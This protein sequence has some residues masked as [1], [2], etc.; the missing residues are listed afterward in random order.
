MISEATVGGKILTADE[1][2]SFAEGR[3]SHLYERLGAHLVQHDGASGVQF[4]VWAPKA[5][6][7]SVVGDFDQWN[8]ETDPLQRA[9]D[10]SGLWTGF[11]RNVRESAIYK[12]YV[13]S[14][15]EGE[16]R[17]KMD[18]FGFFHERSPKTASLVWDLQYAWNDG[19][20]MARQQQRNALDQPISIYEVHF[21][22]WRRVPEEN[23]RFLTYREAA[24]L[25]VQQ[26][27]E[28]GFTHVEF[29]PL[30]EHP[31]YA[32]W[33]YQVTGFFAPTSRY[34]TPQDLM[35]LIDHLHQHGIGVIL[36]WVP[37]H[38][39]NDSHGLGLFD[40]TPTFEPG[41]PQQATHPEWNSYLFDYSRPEVRSFLLSSAFF[42]LEKY[43]AD[44]LR[45]DA[46]A[47]MLYRDHGHA[48]GH[49]SAN[50]S[51]GREN[52]AAADFIRELNT[53]LYAAFPGIQTYAE[54]STAWPKVSRP[55]YAGGLGFGL[56]W[57][58]GFAH[59]ILRYFGRE[60]LFRKLAHNELTFRGLYAFHENFVLPLSHDD[61]IP[62]KGS[63]LARMP[64]NQ[65]ERFSNLRLLL[66]YM[67]LQ[68]GK[69]LLFMGNEFGQWRDWNHDLSLDW[70]LLEQSSH[71]GVAQ[72][73]TDL[74]MTYRRERALHATDV[75]SSSFEWSDCHDAE[76]STISWFRRHADEELLV[77]C[78][79]SQ[80]FYANFRLGVSQGGTWREILNSDAMAYGG[81]GGG[82][83]GTSE[84][85]PFRW[86]QQPYT[87]T[88]NLPAFT[89]IVFKKG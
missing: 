59:D 38:F 77:V 49:W 68:P 31:Y 67:F 57:D 41:D 65:R 45:V 30:M 33:G 32:S 62:G 22:S 70:H 23:N 47:S 16:G 4:T 84:A 54:E 5:A 9:S 15:G 43:H 1:L 18:P 73:V 39:A 3:H 20:W 88:I 75:I 37:S 26:A 85:A 63:L 64:G 61:V 78:N 74:N 21:G 79:L 12:Y 7:V 10:E 89:I 24:P 71:A 25:L 6:R 69:K 46:V 42:W 53:K 83:F 17:F 76:Q 55:T 34:G 58:M 35:Y 11:V 44:G 86:K 66:G 82:N 56:K 87:L 52:L 50:R 48:P 40:G 60:P 19:D 81:G 51:G 8:S 36:D 2:H 80:M 72:W 29:L 27:Q 28:L 14:A 13:V